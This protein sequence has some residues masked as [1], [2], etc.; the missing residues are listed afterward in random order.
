[1]GD[2]GFG[3][4]AAIEMV[5]HGAESVSM[6]CDRQSMGSVRREPERVPV[7]REEIPEGSW[8]GKVDRRTGDEMFE[9]L[10]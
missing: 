2:D 9:T 5:A 1:M 10:Q 8:A 6:G 7:D 4:W 3:A